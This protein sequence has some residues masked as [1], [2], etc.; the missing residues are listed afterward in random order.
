MSSVTLVALA[1]TS[2]RTVAQSV[3]PPASRNWIV[4]ETTS[5]LDYTPVVL[6]VTRSRDGAEQQSAME[7]SVSCRNG[8]TNLTVTGANISGRSDGLS[9]SY[10]VNGDKPIEA[11]AGLGSLGNGVAFRGDI[12][13]L[14]QSF[15]DEGEI[16]IR[17]TTR[18]GAVREA[19]FSLD[20]FKSVRSKVAS[21]CKWP[22]RDN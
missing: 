1:L 8:Q 21:A 18:A 15:P 9:I 16:A 10:R 7:F 22:K 13:R 19:L 3:P 14:L 2:E 17:L 12:V 5:P 6:A 11:G 20:G 4:S